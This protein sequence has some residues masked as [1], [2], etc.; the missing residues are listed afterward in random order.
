MR[1]IRLYGSIENTV[2]VYVDD[3]LV[4]TRTTYYHVILHS[5]SPDHTFYGLM[6]VL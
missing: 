4:M 6:L 5:V 2:H 3:V 1:T